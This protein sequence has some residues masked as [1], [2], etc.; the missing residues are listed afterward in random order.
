MRRPHPHADERPRRIV[1]P[2]EETPLFAAPA[3]TEAQF[4]AKWLRGS[5]AYHRAHGGH[6][7]C[8]MDLLADLKRL[9]V[10]LE[11]P[12]TGTIG[13]LTIAEA[14]RYADAIDP[15]PREAA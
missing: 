3:L 11:L 8:S 5:A 7:E 14:E 2:V 9:G 6:V 1:R 10:H 15:T 12:A 13:L 4:I